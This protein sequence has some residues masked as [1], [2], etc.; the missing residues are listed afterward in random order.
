MQ[1]EFLKRSGERV[2]DRRKKDTREYWREREREREVRS[3]AAVS[4]S[5]KPSQVCLPTN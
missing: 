1:V 4:L 5:M 2:R 3:T